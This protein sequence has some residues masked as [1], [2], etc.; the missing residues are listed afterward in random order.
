[1]S[2]DEEKRFECLRLAMGSQPIPGSLEM[3]V[4][5]SEDILDVAKKYYD[6]VSGKEPMAKG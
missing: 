5:K 1:M 2:H 3:N 4:Y 6:F